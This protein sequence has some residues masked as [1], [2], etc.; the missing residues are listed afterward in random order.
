MIPSNYAREQMATVSRMR[1]LF[2]GTTG[3]NQQPTNLPNDQQHPPPS[4][5]RGEDMARVRTVST[6]EE[7]VYVML[8]YGTTIIHETLVAAHETIK[9][10]NK[11]CC[12][13]EVEDPDPLTLV[14]VQIITDTGRFPWLTTHGVV[15][16][17]H[18]S[19]W[20]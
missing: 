14:R 5:N 18:S 13:S 19:S 2:P 7:N 8:R 20:L 12:Q 11:M 6:L 17:A 10:C 1:D 15:D 3:R 4:A 16:G 9:G